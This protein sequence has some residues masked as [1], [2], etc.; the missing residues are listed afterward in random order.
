LKK[1]NKKVGIYASRYM[2]GSIFGNYDTC[3]QASVNTPLWYAHYDNVPSFS[4]FVA[5]GGWKTPTAKQYFGTSSL[6]G[7]S[8][9]RNWE[10]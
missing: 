5:F 4:D 8:V 1:K 6:C 2:W 9:D 10:P 7:A 3:T